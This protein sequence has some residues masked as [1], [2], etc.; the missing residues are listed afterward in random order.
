MVDRCN[1]CSQRCGSGAVRI[2]RGPTQRM[3]RLRSVRP[4]QRADFE[5]ALRN[6]SSVELQL[7]QTRL[8]EAEMDFV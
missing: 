2:S 5:L 1:R 6:S 3:A 7:Q 8:V 4:D